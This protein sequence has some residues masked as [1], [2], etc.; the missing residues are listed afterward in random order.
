MLWNF[1]KILDEFDL[2][3][4]FIIQTMAEWLE[5][6][7]TDQKIPCSSPDATVTLQGH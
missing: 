5:R 4:S 7:P 3:T 2:T 6:Q 1:Q